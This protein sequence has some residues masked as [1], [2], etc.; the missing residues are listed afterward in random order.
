MPTDRKS[1]KKRLVGPRAGT[2]IRSRTPDLWRV[3]Y[4]IGIRRIRWCRWFGVAH[5]PA[6]I[7]LEL[8]AAQLVAFGRRGKVVE[9]RALLEV[10]GHECR[11]R[12]QSTPEDE[13]GERL[14]LEDVRTEILRLRQRARAEGR[15]GRRRRKR[16]REA[17]EGVP[18][19]QRTFP[20]EKGSEGAPRPRNGEPC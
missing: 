11:H 7:L 12:C 3:L 16:L 6:R 4:P 13:A 14:I 1:N 2:K 20:A 10:C 18:G 17:R 8:A 19:S 5:W 9:E 15:G